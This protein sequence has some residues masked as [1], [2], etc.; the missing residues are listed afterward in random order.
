MRSCE[1]FSHSS[2][3]SSSCEFHSHS[4]S[5]LVAPVNVKLLAPVNVRLSRASHRAP[6]ALRRSPCSTCVGAIAA[7]AHRTALAHG[8]HWHPSSPL[9]CFSSIVPRWHSGSTDACPFVS[10]TN[11]IFSACFS[12]VAR[13]RRPVRLP[14]LHPL[15]LHRHVTAQS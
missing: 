3:T 8:I 4:S 11:M 7:L 1:F 12:A 10:L 2:S 9:S 14:P 13:R 15:A 5:E 6:C